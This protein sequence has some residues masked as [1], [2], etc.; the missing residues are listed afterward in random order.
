MDKWL[1]VNE[2]T[3]MAAGKRLYENFS[4]GSYGG[5]GEE[6]QPPIHPYLS[7][8]SMISENV[9]IAK[10]TIY[11]QIF[12]FFLRNS[13][14]SLRFSVWVLVLLDLEEDGDRNSLLSSIQLKFLGI[15]FGFLGY[16]ANY[17]YPE[18]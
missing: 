12:L 15:W 2:Y 13:C 4:S 11:V 16:N 9:H 10:S 5:V 8:L 17:G 1:W 7:F 6:E 14:P 3:V 18:A